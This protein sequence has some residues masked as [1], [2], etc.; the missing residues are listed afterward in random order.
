MNAKDI[1]KIEDALDYI[2]G[3]LRDFEGGISTIEETTENL[4]EL[5]ITISKEKK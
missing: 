2:E 1:R 4:L 5:L 3:C